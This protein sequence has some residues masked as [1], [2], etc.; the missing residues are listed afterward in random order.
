MDLLPFFLQSLLS[1]QLP[2]NAL[3]GANSVTL[4]TSFPGRFVTQHL[5]LLTIIDLHEVASLIYASSA[6]HRHA[7]LVQLMEE[8]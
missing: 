5:H 1:G 2:H 4:S 7:R 8:T 6:I 3:V